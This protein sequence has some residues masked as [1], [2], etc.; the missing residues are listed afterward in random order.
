MDINK[1]EKLENVCLQLDRLNLTISNLVLGI[2]LPIFLMIFIVSHFII[3]KNA[4]TKFLKWVNKFADNWFIKKF[5]F[6]KS[7]SQTTSYIYQTLAL[8]IT[9]YL[10]QALKNGVFDVPFKLGFMIHMLNLVIFLI[11][12]SVTLIL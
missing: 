5:F 1:S 6:T 8:I 7:T 10:G 9:V 4:L 11:L 3:T 12:L 2:V